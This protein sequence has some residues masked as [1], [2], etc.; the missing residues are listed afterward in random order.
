MLILVV[1]IVIVFILYPSSSPK[2]EILS[3][4]EKWVNSTEGTLVFMATDNSGGTI[5]CD[6][7]LNDVIIR[8][9]NV[10][11]GVQAEEP[12]TLILGTNEIR[13]KATDFAGHSTWSDTFIVHVDFE[14]PIIVI[15]DFQVSQ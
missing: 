15:V 7:E 13:V 9:V 3:E 4:S 8:T 11:S 12:L 6:V 5:V 1:C 10:S 14:P 2:V